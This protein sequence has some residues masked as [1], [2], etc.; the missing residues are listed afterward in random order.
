MVGGFTEDL[1][2][3]QNCQKCLPLKM[4]ESISKK[5]AKTA[6]KSAQTSSDI[7]SVRMSN[8]CPVIPSVLSPLESPDVSNKMFLCVN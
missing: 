5:N 7:T 8:T 2:K 6:T 1:K 4:T 3:L